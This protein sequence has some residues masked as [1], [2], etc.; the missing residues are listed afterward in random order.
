MQKLCLTCSEPVGPNRKKF[1]SQRCA[2]KW[3]N[4]KQEER[5]REDP[6]LRAALRRARYWKDPE[7]ARNQMRNWRAKNPELATQIEKR[8]WAKHTDQRKQKS[9]A[10]REN[11]RDYLRARATQFHYDTRANTPWKHILRSRFRDALKRGIPFELTA[12]W[13]ANRWTGYCELSGIP[14]DLNNSK[15]G[16][17]SPSIDKIIPEKGYL[18]DNSRFVLLAVNTFKFNGTDAD[19]YRT[20]EAILTLAAQKALPCKL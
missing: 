6:E 9:A 8:R 3:H 17:Y 18:P 1:C 15:S 4:A 20:A 11:N 2:M 10:W 5:A 7:R 12:E 16:F 13:A 19:V 14:F